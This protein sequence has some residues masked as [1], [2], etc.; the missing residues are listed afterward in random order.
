MDKGQIPPKEFADLIVTLYKRCQAENGED[1]VDYL[2]AVQQVMPT[3]TKMTKKPF[4]FIYDENGDVYYSAVKTIGKKL[5]VETFKI[6]QKD[7]EV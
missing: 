7:K 6:A 1:Y 2:K 4:G 5:V 3:A